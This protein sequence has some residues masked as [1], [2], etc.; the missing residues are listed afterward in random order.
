MA[1]PP[2][3]KILGILLL[4]GGIVLGYF[5]YQKLDENKAEIKIGDLELS[6]KDK[7][8]TTTAYIMMGAGA[9]ALIA[10][11]VLLSRKSS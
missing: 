8:Q 5:G 7:D 2:L 4:L 6:A 9:V 10:G 1:K 3:M 11:A